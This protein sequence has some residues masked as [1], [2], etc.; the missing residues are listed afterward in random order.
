MFYTTIY[1]KHLAKKSAQLDDGLTTEL[2]CWDIW[3][4]D[5]S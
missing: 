4:Q 3:E 1:I 5:K 2:Q